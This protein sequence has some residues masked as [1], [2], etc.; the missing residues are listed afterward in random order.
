MRH[1]AGSLGVIRLDYNSPPA[2][3]DIDHPA[4]Y[5]YDVFYK[6]VPGLTFAMCQSGK[7]TPEV[8][9]R[10]LEAIDYFEA[11]GVSGI[12]GD[13]GFMMY[14]QQLARCNTKKPIFMS[15]LVQLPAV[16]SCY[17]NDEHVAIFTANGESLK[18][19]LDLIR[20]E[21]GV[22]TEGQRF[23]IV[24]CENVPH[25][26]AVALGEKVPVDKVTE[27]MV[28]K[29][30]EALEADPTIR[31]ILLECTELPPYADALRL[32]TG[33]PVYDGSRAATSS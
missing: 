22:H 1:K 2:P 32:A 14:L 21:C 12:T 16:T 15:A 23:V 33:L 28:A 26:E 9:A 30:K 6:V 17:A 20:E 24:G 7:L 10:F 27:G 13:C 18:P 4:S 19:M 3:G 5:K 25:F 8:E 31:A 11:L 29:A